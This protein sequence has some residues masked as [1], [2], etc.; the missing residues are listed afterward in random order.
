MHFTPELG[1]RRRRRYSTIRM[2]RSSRTPRRRKPTARGIIG[3]GL[4]VAGLLVGLAIPQIVAA[5]GPNVEVVGLSVNGQA[6]PMLGLGDTSP[7]LSWRMQQTQAA[8]SHRCNRSGPSVACPGDKQTAYQIQVAGSAGA[9][10]SGNLLWDSGKVASDQQAG[11]AYGGQPLASRQRV[12]WRVRVW[13]ADGAP[14]NWSATAS[15]E[16]GLTEQEDWGDARWID[17]PGRTEGQP[18]PIFARQFDVDGQRGEGA[19]LPVGDRR[20]ARDGQ[21]QL[22]DRRGP[23]ARL[24]QLAAR[25]PS[26]GRTTSPTSSWP[27]RTPWVSS[28]ATAPPTSDGA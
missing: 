25:R 22:A 17:Y 12:A 15:F 21:R 9:L 2:V 23:G 18:L 20:P 16:L 10:T 11:I 7:I 26:T 5:A 24:L 6:E 28:W 27:A 14:S 3:R 4:V 13:D 8:K 1:R 19:P